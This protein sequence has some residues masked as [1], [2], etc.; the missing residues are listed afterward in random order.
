MLIYKGRVYS[1]VFSQK[2]VSYKLSKNTYIFDIL[3]FFDEIFLMK[4][5]VF[6][7]FDQKVP[8][9]EQKV[10]VCYKNV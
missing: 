9:I 4:V 5:L 6:Q 10:E 2:E 8:K 3:G 1:A 7:N